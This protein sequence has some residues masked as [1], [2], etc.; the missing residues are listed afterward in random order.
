MKSYLFNVH[1]AQQYC[2]GLSD[3]IRYSKYL[4]EDLSTQVV[5]ST[6]LNY[7]FNNKYE[8]LHCNVKLLVHE[9]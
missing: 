8:I 4:G 3:L 6:P 5:E 9:T 1:K 7:L 2:F